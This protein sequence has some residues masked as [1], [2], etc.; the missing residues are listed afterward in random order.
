MA[1]QIRLIL[2]SHGAP[3]GTDEIKATR[4]QLGWQCEPLK[5]PRLSKHITTARKRETNEAQAWRRNFDQWSAAFPDARVEFD[6]MYG[7]N[8]P[9]TLAEALL[10]VVPVSGATRKL[11]QAAIA[12]IAQRCPNF[13][14]GSADLTGSNGALIKHSPVFG[15]P[16]E[17]LEAYSGRQLY[18]GFESMR[19]PPLPMD[20][21]SWWLSTVYSN[22]SRIQDYC[23]AFDKI[24]ALSKLPTL[25]VFTHDSIFL[26][27]DGPT[28]QPIE[29]HWALR[30][31]PN[32]MY[33]RPADGVEV[34]MAWA[35]AMGRTDGPVAFGL[36]RQNLP[37]LQ[38][39]T[40]VTPAEVLKGGYAGYR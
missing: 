20:D 18:F 40:A 37:A 17:E 24:G 36:T 35:Y 21:T 14:G 25:F 13:V 30:M 29:H 28:H 12:E 7:S 32:L 16:C 8:T 9:N 39:G 26:G 19:W 10:D 34:A 11:S 38:R 31:I 1:A 22:I 6:E 15:R 4:A 2:R 33:F 5:F 3:L 23:R 27:E